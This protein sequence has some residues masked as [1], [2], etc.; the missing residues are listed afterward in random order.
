MASGEHVR[1]DR[2]LRSRRSTIFDPGFNGANEQ[3]HVVVLGGAGSELVGSGENAVQ[4]LL[5]SVDAIGLTEELLGGNDHA[6]FTP[7]FL[8]WGHSFGYAVGEGEKK[9]AGAL[10]GGD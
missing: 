2:P 1:E 5:G 7:L 3:S 10:G 6:V 9:M 4:E 8:L